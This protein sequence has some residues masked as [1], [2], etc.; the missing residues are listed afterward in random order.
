MNRTV[1]RVTMVVGGVVLSAVGVLVALLAVTFS[2]NVPMPAAGPVPE[3]D[4]ALI[5]DG[6]V[7]VY[8]IPTTS[9]SVALIDCG[10]DP[11]AKAVK[12]WLAAEKKTVDAIFITHG[13][14]DHLHGCKA[15]G[16][17]PIHALPAEA[18]LMIGEIP[19]KG[20]LPRMFGPTHLGVAIDRPLEDGKSVTIGRTTITPYAVPGHTPGSA[21]YVARGVLFFGDAATGGSDGQVKAAPWLFSDDVAMDIESLHALAKRIDPTLVAT[22]AYAHSGPQ[23]ADLGKLALAQ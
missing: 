18:E 17:A 14:P 21:V 10:N 1:K 11:E 5:P 4:V 8:A 15:L 22:F 20:P 19:F 6:Y 7:A 23:K 2:G 9:T 13:H 16:P 3:S 12:A